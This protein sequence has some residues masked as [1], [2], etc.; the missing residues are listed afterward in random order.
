MKSF[1]QRVKTLRKQMRMSQLALARACG[2]SQTTISDIE[3]GRNQTS[4]EIVALARA[5]NTTA[6]ALLDGYGS[7]EAAAF[8]PLT[9]HAEGSI[10][11]PPSP[12]P[13]G[14]RQQQGPPLLTADEQA[15]LDAYRLLEPAD[16]EDL[17]VE[18]LRR[19]ERIR[20]YMVKAQ[21]QR[22]TSTDPDETRGD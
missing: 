1:G 4:A 22:Q 6:E 8:P 20:R 16:R 17:V 2:I 12:C 18:L 3:R 11:H 21:A 13:S 7:Q 15:L 19:A 5:L 9:G 10:S 14:Q